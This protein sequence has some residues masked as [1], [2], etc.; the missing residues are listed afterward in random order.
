MQVAAASFQAD[1]EKFRLGWQSGEPARAVGPWCAFLT[2]SLLTCPHM[3]TEPIRIK[4][5]PFHPPPYNLILPYSSPRIF[6]GAIPTFSH[7]NYFFH[8][9]HNQGQPRAVQT[10]PGAHPAPFTMG[11]GSFPRVKRP[12]NRLYHPPQSIAEVEERVELYLY[13]RLCL[14]G[15]LYGELYL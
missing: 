11:N 4:S 14:H 6:K 15:S 13:Y 9:T 2:C 7:I 12:G 10:G 5:A 1:D 3:T 8:L